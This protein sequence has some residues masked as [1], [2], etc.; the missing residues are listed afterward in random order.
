MLARSS[1]SQLSLSGNSSNGASVPLV[2]LA[3]R[4]T[5]IRYFY[6]DG[7]STSV[8]YLGDICTLCSTGDENKLE[9]DK[10]AKHIAPAQLQVINDVD[11]S[12]NLPPS[13]Q[14]HPFVTVDGFLK[15]VL[16]HGNLDLARLCLYQLR[17]FIEGSLDCCLDNFIRTACV[18][19]QI[20]QS[21]KDV[22]QNLLLRWDRQ[23]VLPLSPLSS[24]RQAMRILFLQSEA[25]WKFVTESTTSKYVIP[26]GCVR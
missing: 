1:S 12:E 9:L 21:A 16:N 18:C 17:S 5:K 20:V 19:S 13:K 3:I 7:G 8:F 2:S 22:P 4:D 15:V 23:R 25:G 14:G 11:P 26:V 24:M 6:L 10:V